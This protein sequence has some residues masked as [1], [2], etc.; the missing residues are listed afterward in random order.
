MDVAR[1]IK[2]RKELGYS[3]VALSRGI[4]TQSTLSKFEREGQ[5]PSLAIL[6]GL[7]N[8]LGLSLDDLTRQDPS[9]VR[10]AADA[11]DQVEEDLM[12]EDFPR[13]ATGLAKLDGDQFQN[14]QAKLRYYYLVGMNAT[15]TNQ[16]GN[17]VLFAFSHV[18]D[19][20]DE[21]H[22]TVYSALAYLG[23]GIFY[24]RHD[25]MDRAAFFFERVT[26]DLD[27]WLAAAPVDDRG[28]DYLHLLVILYYLA[29]YRL[30]VEDRVAAQHLVKLSLQICGHRH[31][32]YFLPRIKLL[33]AEMALDAG[34]AATVVATY[35]NDASAFARL[36]HNGVVQVQVAALKNRL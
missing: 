20:L 9:S 29:E 12:I 26:K 15:L 6:T 36:N 1:F 35:L 23:L 14:S 27:R 19:E 3:Q 34:A 8:R 24:T 31:V 28:Q 11:L 10:F 30:L 16:G 17:E 7:C 5:V 32:T 4:C 33:Q 25:T 21:H 18:L 22:Q 2:R 13:V